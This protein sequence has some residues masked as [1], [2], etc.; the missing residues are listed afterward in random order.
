MPARENVK[1]RM[2]GLIKRVRTERLRALKK[3]VA[4]EEAKEEQA[5]PADELSALEAML[6]Q[7]GTEG[8]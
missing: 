5:P 3:P 7:G 2:F 8:G 4:K 6:G 1:L